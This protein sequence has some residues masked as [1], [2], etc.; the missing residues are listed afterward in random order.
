[1]IAQ[2]KLDDAG[3]G[4]QLCYEGEDPNAEEVLDAAMKRCG[5]HM[6]ALADEYQNPM[7]IYVN[8]CVSSSN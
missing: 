8:H 6:P 2:E 5:L 1:M 4:I 7:M 3:L